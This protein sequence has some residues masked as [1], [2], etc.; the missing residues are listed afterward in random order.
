MKQMENQ[1]IAKSEEFSV[2]LDPGQ[3]DIVRLSSKSHSVLAS[4]LRDKRQLSEITTVEYQIMTIFFDDG[5]NWMA[6]SFSHPNLID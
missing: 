2:S 1:E 5:S 4:F 6:G 3:T